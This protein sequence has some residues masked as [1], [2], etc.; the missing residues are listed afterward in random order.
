MVKC[1]VRHDGIVLCA[2][3]ETRPFEVRQG[4]GV[5]DA[6]PFIGD[7][8]DSAGVEA[9]R[10]SKPPARNPRKQRGGCQMLSW[11]WKKR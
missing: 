5:V 10:R 2:G 1:Y 4:L 7:G 8:S 9:E 6:Q 11:L 3:R